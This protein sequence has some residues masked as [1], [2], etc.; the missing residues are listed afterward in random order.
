[1]TAGAIG[2]SAVILSDYQTIIPEQ[3]PKTWLQTALGAIEDVMWKADASQSADSGRAGYSEGPHYFRYAMLN[4]LPFFRA[5]KH[6]Y[7][8]TFF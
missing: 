5:L 6:V 1:M 3:Q 7:P 4:M 2:M 8:D